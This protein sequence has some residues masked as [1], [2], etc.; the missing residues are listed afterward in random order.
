[1]KNVLEDPYITVKHRW[2]ESDAWLAH[3]KHDHPNIWPRGW[4]SSLHRVGGPAREYDTGKVEWFFKGKRIFKFSA[5]CNLVEPYMT[6]E[7]YLVMILTYGN[8][9]E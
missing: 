9:Y 6:D 5:Y 3:H 7:D 8:M 4:S 2:I 1:M